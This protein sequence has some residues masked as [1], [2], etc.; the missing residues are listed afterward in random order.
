MSIQHLHCSS[1]HIKFCEMSL[2]TIHAEKPLNNSLH[3]LNTGRAGV[4]RTIFFGPCTLLLF[5]GFGWMGGP[6][7]FFS[8]SSQSMALKNG[9]LLIVCAAASL[10]A[11]SLFRNFWFSS[12]VSSQ[13]EIVC[14]S[15]GTLLPTITEKA[16]CYALITQIGRAHV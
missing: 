4:M 7:C 16:T 15:L 12:T 2:V 13:Q 10:C 14:G 6:T 5:T 11:G 8:S 3:A 1:S 9:W